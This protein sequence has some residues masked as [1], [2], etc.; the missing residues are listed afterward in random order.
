LMI[1]FLTGNGIGGGFGWFFVGVS[2]AS[3][4]LIIDSKKQD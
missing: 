1:G 3:A 4:K 2:S